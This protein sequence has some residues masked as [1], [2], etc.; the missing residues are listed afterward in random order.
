[1]KT[2]RLQV[3][4]T[5][6]AVAVFIGILGLYWTALGENRQWKLAHAVQSENAYASMT[7]METLEA[8]LAALESLMAGLE[9]GHRR[10]GLLSEDVGVLV[11]EQTALL[12]LTMAEVAQIQGV[13]LAAL[14][15]T[16]DGV[17]Y[18]RTNRCHYAVGQ[19]ADALKDQ[20]CSGWTSDLADAFEDAQDVL[21]T[22]LEVLFGPPQIDVPGDGLTSY[23]F[24]PIPT[25][26][27]ETVT[28]TLLLYAEGGEESRIGLLA[29]GMAERQAAETKT[30]IMEKAELLGLTM[31]EVAEVQGIRLEDLEKRDSGYF[32]S[33]NQCSYATY[34]TEEPIPLEEQ[35]CFW[36]F[37]SFSDMFG[38]RG[39]T[40]LGELE[41]LFGAPQLPY[42]SQSHWRF[43]F[44]TKQ[45]DNASI[46]VYPDEN[47]AVPEDSEVQ[48]ILASEY[49]GGAS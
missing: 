32:D 6:L 30:V 12:G 21:L 42:P 15:K 31:D 46:L 25:E 41:A 17:Y 10:L 35:R 28:L 45:G 14:E 2:K 34:P 11:A 37:E 26:L 19:T 3:G 9:G 13:T 4:L 39:E 18:D 49:D 7:Q 27:A 36:Y 29:E 48:I 43:W 33:V 1:M 16:A 38:E 22:K 40:I 20:I 44:T 23:R 24:S 47:G 8:E 5:I